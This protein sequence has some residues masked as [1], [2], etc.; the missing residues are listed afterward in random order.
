LFAAGDLIVVL[1][2]LPAAPLA[3]C[4]KYLT[5]LPG[6]AAPWRLLQFDKADSAATLSQQGNNNSPDAQ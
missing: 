6:P 1:R 4:R 2:L 3:V 5:V